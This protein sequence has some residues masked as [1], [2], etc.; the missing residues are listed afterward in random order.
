M[1]E[2]ITIDGVDIPAPSKYSVMMADLDSP[3]STRNEKGI[4]IR[5]RIREGVYKI[6]LEFN[7]KT[8]DEIQIIESAIKKD[9]LKVTFPDTSGRITKNMYVGDRKKEIVLYNNGEIDKMRWNLSFNLV[10]Y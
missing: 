8:G 4:L 1:S 9:K 10:E 6:E 7:V 5:R 3:D 2:I